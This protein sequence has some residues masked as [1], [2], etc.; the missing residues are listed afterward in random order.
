MSCKQEF[1]MKN[2]E[3]K[4]NET[5]VNKKHQACTLP[6]FDS[7]IKEPNFCVNK[8]NFDRE[9]VQMHR[10]IRFIMYNKKY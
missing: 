6:F 2:D 4:Q 5:A 8:S 1:K 10:Q 9:V 3:C 7:F